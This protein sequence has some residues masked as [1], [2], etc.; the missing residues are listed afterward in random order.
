[1]HVDLEDLSAVKKRLSIEV[2]PGEVEQE[3]EGVLRNF[4]KKA[5][6]PGFRPGKTPASV[7][8]SRFAK[9]IREEVKENLIRSSFLNAARERDLNPISDPALEEVTFEE[10]QP[11]SFKVTFE[12]LPDFEVKDYR[13]IEVR[14]SSA[15]VPPAEIDQQL[16]QLQLARVKHVYEKGR[17]AAEGDLVVADVVGTPEEGESFSRES[18]QVILGAKEN[19][20]EFNEHLA[21]AQEGDEKEFPVRYPEGYPGK[22]LAG[23]RVDFRLT[24]KEVKRRELP[25]LDDEFAK[26]LGDFSGMDELRSRVEEDLQARK[27]HEA[28]NRVRE[29]LL[30]KVLLQNAIP[31]PE[32]LTE[33]EIRHRMEEIVR[34]MLNQGIDPQNSKVDWEKIRKQ[35]E[36][37]ARKS[38]HARLVLDAIAKA[39]GLEVD[40]KKVDERIR[41]EAARMDETPESLREQLNKGSGMQALKNQLLREVTLDYLTSVANIQSEE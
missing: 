12:V 25:E 30:D 29:A 8:R 35:Q 9:E 22:E 40:R 32:V 18:T 17:P 23:K 36:E 24:V 39:E 13:G 6:I 5:R 28:E 37:P 33:S 20:P 19:L 41:L 16:A 38:V 15:Q 4:R 21:G 27:K 1:M 11:L 7:I 31:L 3:T 14:R 26:D 10:G 34:G 2:P